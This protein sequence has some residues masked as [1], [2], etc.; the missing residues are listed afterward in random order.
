MISKL[1]TDQKM[2]VRRAHERLK[3]ARLCV[4]MV[5]RLLQESFAEASE[6]STFSA[7]F[8]PSSNEGDATFST[9]FGSGRAITV[10]AIV[11]GKVLVRY[12]FE[13]EATD[14]FGSKFY[15]PLGEICF[16]EEGRVTAEDGEQLTDLNSPDDHETFVAIAELG[17]ALVYACAV[18]SRI[19]PK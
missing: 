13:K 16:D 11:E 7:S 14:Q 2:L 3:H 9:D 15:V 12:V 17:L 18:E 19:S 5:E 10:N 8:V 1:D 4:G 6:R